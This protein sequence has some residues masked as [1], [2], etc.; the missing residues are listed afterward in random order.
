ML[1]DPIDAEVMD[2]AGPQLKVISNYAVGYDNIDVAAA[3]ERGIVV[4]NTPG[5]LT[6]AT[7]DIA[8]AL[9]I[10]VARRLGEGVEFVKRGEWKTWEPQTLLGL[11]LV[12]R[13]VGIVGLGKIGLA[14]ARRCLGFDMKLIYYDHK[15]REELG[16]EVG[17]EMA[18]SLDELLEKS[19][20][21]SLH[22]PLTDATRGLIGADEFKKMKKTAV[23]VNTSRGPVVDTDALYN[24]LSTGEIAYAGLDV[25]D[26]EPL[27]SDHKLLT[28]PN[29]LVI[30]HLGS[31][32]VET[33]AKMAVMAAENLLAGLKGERPPNCVNPGALE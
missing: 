11:D 19:D 5:V 24:A 6:D 4:G 16:G 30:P 20:F 25:T 2:A 3:N 31:A 15:M 21:V 17:A 27:P 22:C 32:S 29:C 18:E 9:M 33:R 12:W 14:M 26:P 13:T 8:F 10:G 23:L 1:S 7:A 28:L